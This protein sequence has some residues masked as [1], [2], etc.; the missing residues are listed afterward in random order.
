MG[1]VSHL[2]L[3]EIQLKHVDIYENIEFV[4]PHPSNCVA[5]DTVNSLK[6]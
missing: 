3:M 4:T 1:A 5:K 6:Y 2:N